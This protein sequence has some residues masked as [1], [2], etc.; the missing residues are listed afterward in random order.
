MLEHYPHKLSFIYDSI[1]CDVCKNSK[2][3]TIHT[4]K[5]PNTFLGWTV[6]DEIKCKNTIYLWREEISISEKDLINMYGK[7]IK[8]RRSSG[9]IEDDWEIY[10]RAYKLHPNDTLWI[11]VKNNKNVKSISIEDMDILNKQ[12]V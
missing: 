6:C 5:V 3:S 1:S 7:N 10:G 8:I 4:I 12:S 11:S 2:T 9:V